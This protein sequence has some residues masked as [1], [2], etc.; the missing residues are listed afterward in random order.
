MTASMDLRQPLA[1]MIALVEGGAHLD[2]RNRAGNTPMHKAAMTGQRGPIQVRSTRTWFGVT[3]YDV[4]PRHSMHRHHYLYL[5]L[6]LPTLTLTHHKSDQFSHDLR[7]YWTVLV[8]YTSS[9]H[10]CTI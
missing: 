7:I 6:R 3:C 9:Y 2:Y 1:M 4:T 5:L 10:S 8:F